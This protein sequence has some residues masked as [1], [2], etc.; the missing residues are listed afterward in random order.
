MQ[1]E[2]MTSQSRSQLHG[3]ISTAAHAG[4]YGFAER[5]GTNVSALLEALGLALE[6]NRADKKKSLPPL[7][8]TVVSEAQQIASARSRRGRRWP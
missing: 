5:H 6:A 1:R 4:W 2:A 7:L 8:K 3:Y